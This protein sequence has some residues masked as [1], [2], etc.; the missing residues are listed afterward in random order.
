MN[1]L[2]TSALI[3]RFVREPGSDVVA[4]LLESGDPVATATRLPSPKCIDT[5]HG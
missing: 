2:D 4:E 5:P 1:Y 3:K